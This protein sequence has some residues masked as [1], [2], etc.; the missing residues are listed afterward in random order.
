MLRGGSRET[1]SNYYI[2]QDVCVGPVTK[3]LQYKTK[4]QSIFD[5]LHEFCFKVK[6]NTHK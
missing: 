3:S 4:P 2:K 1:K 5:N 6:I